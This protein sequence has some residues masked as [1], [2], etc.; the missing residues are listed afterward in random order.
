MMRRCFQSAY[1]SL[2]IACLLYLLQVSE[3][4]PVAHVLHFYRR[5]DMAVHIRFMRR[6]SLVMRDDAKVPRYNTAVPAYTAI[7]SQCFYK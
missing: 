2:F 5:T 3:A 6:D 4:S 1:I 7:L